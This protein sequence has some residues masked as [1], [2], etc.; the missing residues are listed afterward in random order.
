MTPLELSALRQLLTRV[1]TQQSRTGPDSDTSGVAAAARLAYDDLARLLA[2]LIGRVG[3]DA[4][5]ARAVH[6]AQ[7]EYPWLAT[8]RESEQAGGPFAQVNVSLER[9]DPA[10]ATEAAATVLA[11]FTGLLVT[12]IGQPLTTRLMR[13]AWPDGFSEAGAEETRA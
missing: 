6:L 7:R 8:S 1:L 13:Q 4:L 10:L 9:Q 2:P 12:F 5:S 11:I 3:V